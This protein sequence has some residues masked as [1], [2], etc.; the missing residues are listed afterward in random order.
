[1]NT[2]K[3]VG[4]GAAKSGSQAFSAVIDEMNNDGTANL[5]SHEKALKVYQKLKGSGISFYTAPVSNPL[6]FIQHF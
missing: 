2:R 5:P 1:M 6:N 3:D 4:G